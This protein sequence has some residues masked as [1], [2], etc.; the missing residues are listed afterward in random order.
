MM[1]V[2]MDV[3]HVRLTC[4][5]LAGAALFAG[6]AARGQNIDAGKRFA[7][8]SCSGCHRIDGEAPKTTSDEV[9]SFAA[10]AR[11]KS[12]TEMSLAAF[13]MTPHANMP[14]LV[15]SRTEIRDVSAY[16]LSLR[17]PQ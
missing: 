10:I 11:M 15:L 3:M 7:Q 17:Q 9:P 14:N 5:V 8:T 1:R 12:T 4:A 6:G 13:L 2:Q 16:I